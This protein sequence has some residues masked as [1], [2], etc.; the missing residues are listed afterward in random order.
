MPLTTPVRMRRLRSAAGE[1][2]GRAEA[3]RIHHRDGTR[4]HGED[5]AQDAAH[6]GGRALKRFDVARVIVRLDLERDHPAA[7]D[8]DDAGVFAR[9]LHDVLALRGELLQMD[10][11]ALVGAVL[12]PHHAED[13]EF[14]VGRFAAEQGD[15]FLVLRGRE[16]ML[17]DQLR[18]DGH[19][20][21]AGTAESMRFEDAEPVDR[22]HQRIAGALGM[23]HHAHDVALAV[24]NAGDVAER[25]VRIIHVAE[26]HAVFGFELIERAFVGEIAAF[27]VRDRQVQ[28]L[29][30][31]QV[32]R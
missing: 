9:S 19:L 3:Q 25:A 5:V 31:R 22:T 11:R 14:G 23:R 26:R 15:D 7:A 24:Q 32:S 6:A 28:Q 20:V 18:C 8:T 21:S 17:L 12:A 29:A 16:L 4:A 2:V 10:A 30:L 1:F 13:A 27:A